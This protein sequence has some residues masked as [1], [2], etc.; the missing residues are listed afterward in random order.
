MLFIR[1]LYSPFQVELFWR[2][3]KEERKYRIKLLVNINKS[4]HI[5]MRIIESFM[6]LIFYYSI[7][8]FVQGTR[9]RILFLTYN[10]VIWNVQ[11]A[12]CWKTR[13]GVCV[14]T[15]FYV[16]HNW[17]SRCTLSWHYTFISL[18]NIN[19]KSMRTISFHKSYPISLGWTNEFDLYMSACDTFA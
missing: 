5:Y 19:E 8:K 4:T 15:K 3:M 9:K 11:R 7:T 14:L 13:F 17:V 18:F 16:Y 6:K 1:N 10:L 12:K 2:N